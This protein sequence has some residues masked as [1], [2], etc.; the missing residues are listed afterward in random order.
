MYPSNNSRV[1]A[2]CEE[3]G[4][5]GMLEA[6]SATGKEFRG[7][8]AYDRSK[9]LFVGL[10]VYGPGGNVGRGGSREYEGRNLNS[11][12]AAVNTKLR[13]KMSSSG[14]VYH[15][16]GNQQ[17]LLDGRAVRDNLDALLR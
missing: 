6:A 8:V 16:V 13:A 3:I 12:V 1:H 17:P 10:T 4:S 5:G 15:P 7:H 14:S 2:N 11:A 9:K